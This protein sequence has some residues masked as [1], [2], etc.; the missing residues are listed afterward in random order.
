MKNHKNILFIIF[1]SLSIHQNAPYFDSDMAYNFLIDQCKIGTRYPGSIE[2]VKT[3]DY[4]VNYLEDRVDSLIIDK[5]LITHPY[6]DKKIEL[7]NILGKFNPEI[8]NRIML[9]AHWDT[10]E[11]ADKDPNVENV[12]M[13]ILGA[14][15]GASGIAVLMVLADMLN[16]YPLDNIGIDLLFVDGE[17]MGRSGDIEH[18]SIGTKLFSKSI[19]HNNIKFAICLDMVADKDAEFKIERFSFMQAE[20][21]VREI[22]ALANELGYSEF[23]YNMQHP[24]YDDHRAL[25]V[26]TGIPSL[27]IIDFD[28]PYWHTLEDTPDKCSARTLGIVGNVVSEYI[29]RIDKG[30]YE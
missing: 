28:Y 11:I 2:H 15:D 27:D 1:I 6:L 16:D 23:T 19:N 25:F 18:F 29:Y 30:Q 10:R 21:Q 22:W 9:L 4:I 14:N 26:E 12:N 20:K 24:I 7:F 3:K 13:P 17:D 8:E 5:H